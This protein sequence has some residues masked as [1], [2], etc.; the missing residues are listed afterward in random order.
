[1][2]YAKLL[3]NLIGES[4]AFVRE[5]IDE[6]LWETLYILNSKRYETYSCCCGHGVKDGYISFIETSPVCPTFCRYVNKMMIWDGRV[7]RIAELVEWANNLP[8][9]ETKPSPTYVINK[10]NKK[11]NSRFAGQFTLQGV[12]DWLDR[13]KFETIRVGKYEKL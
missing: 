9:I 5:D 10:V 6:E 1:M 11:G 13:N 2:D 8:S 7:D 12:L 4:E 3:A